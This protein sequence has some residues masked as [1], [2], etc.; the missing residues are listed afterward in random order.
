MHMVF[1]LQIIIT[2][3]KNKNTI[4]WNTKMR[5]RADLGQAVD[6]IHYDSLETSVTFY[7]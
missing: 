3:K 4:A 6:E 5:L 1:S 2:K 7:Q